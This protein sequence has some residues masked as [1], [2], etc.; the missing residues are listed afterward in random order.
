MTTF[1]EPLVALR[2]EKITREAAVA[3]IAR[4]YRQWVDIFEQAKAA[5]PSSNTAA[6]GLVG[7]PQG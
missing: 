6:P 3:E 7:A 5:A 2:D 4:L 1:W